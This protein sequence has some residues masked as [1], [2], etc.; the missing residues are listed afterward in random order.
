MVRDPLDNELPSNVGQ[1]V[2]G[3]P[4]SH[5]DLLIDPDVVRENYASE[6]KKQREAIKKEFARLNIDMVEITTDKDFVR[7]ILRLFEMR[8]KRG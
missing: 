2:V 4:F 3:D 6:T 8:A 1:V 5:E 7:P